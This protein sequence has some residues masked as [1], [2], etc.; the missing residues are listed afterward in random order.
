M[1][2]QLIIGICG[3]SQSGKSTLTRW[4]KKELSSAGLEVKV[5]EMDHYTVKKEQIPRVKDRLDWEHPDSIDWDRLTT[6]IKKSTVDVILV[7]GIFAFDHRISPLYSKKVLI[8]LDKETFLRRRQ[9]EIRWGEEPSWYLEHV[10]KTNQALI[11]LATPDLR[12]MFDGT[13]NVKRV[14]DMITPHLSAKRPTHGSI[15]T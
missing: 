7:E 1:D 11:K 10:W 15:S 5:F 3:I 6:Q 9:S 4:L 13:D 12:L 8:E 14:M 2:K